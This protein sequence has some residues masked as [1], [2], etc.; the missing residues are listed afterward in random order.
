MAPFLP[1]GAWRVT[2]DLFANISTWLPESSSMSAYLCQKLMAAVLLCSGAPKKR[3][4]L[5]H[6][7]VMIHQP[8]GGVKGQASDIFIEAREIERTREELF[9]IMATPTG[10]TLEQIYCD[11]DRDFWMTSSQAVEYGMVDRIL[12]KQK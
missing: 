12:S 7:R 3:L 8:M 9:A 1:Y 11:A 10:K 4:I 5:P 6:A 2:P